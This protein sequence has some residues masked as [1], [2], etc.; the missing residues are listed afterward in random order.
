M[1]KFHREEHKGQK[2]APGFGDILA[3]FHPYPLPLPFGERSQI[4]TGIQEI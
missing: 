4:I 1:K 2:K 3:I